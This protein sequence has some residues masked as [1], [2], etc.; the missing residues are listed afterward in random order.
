MIKRIF[1]ASIV[2]IGLS[3]SVFG[4]VTQ[5]G[6]STREVTVYLR[7][8][9]HVHGYQTLSL[10]QG[11]ISVRVDPFTQQHIP[12]NKIRSV[13][14]GPPLPYP[15]NL[16]PTTKGEFFFTATFGVQFGDVANGD[17]LAA[18]TLTG[19]YVL[20]PKLQLGLGL[21]FMQYDLLTTQT[22]FSRVH[23]LLSPSRWSLFYFAE[24]GLS[25]VQTGRY[26]F[27]TELRDAKGGVT[28]HAGLG[29][30]RSFQGGA[31]FFQVGYRLQKAQLDYVVQDFWGGS[32]EVHE[33][34]TYR[35]VTTT[36]GFTF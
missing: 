23:G 1:L 16:N 22:I 21:G 18:I 26:G 28:W 19:G 2:L 27:T 35:K 14:Y 15:P 17:N 6:D 4:Q 31:V 11:Y 3:T 33:K 13:H 24:A 29:I 10:F 30:Q 32:L 5:A 8:G 20:D 34:K 12:Y 25:R 36:I 7:D 9:S